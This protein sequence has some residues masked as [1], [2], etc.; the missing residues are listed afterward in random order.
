M[1]E[2]RLE[3]RKIAKILITKRHLQ[4]LHFFGDI[5]HSPK[6]RD[7]S[8]CDLPIDCFNAGLGPQIEQ[9]EIEHRLR[10][11]ADFVSIMEILEA[12]F[13]TEIVVNLDNVVHNLRIVRRGFNLLAVRALFNRAE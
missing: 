4:L 13:P 11:L 3:H 1:V 5:V 8:P 9:A 2:E 10:A 6:H 12:I 7:N